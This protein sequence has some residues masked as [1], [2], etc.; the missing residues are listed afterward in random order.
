MSRKAALG[1]SILALVLS[2]HC[3]SALCPHA[4]C[5]PK[6][7]KPADPNAGNNV[8]ADFNSVMSGYARVEVVCTGWQVVCPGDAENTGSTTQQ[9]GPVYAQCNPIRL[10][11]CVCGYRLVAGCAGL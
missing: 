9:Q 2:N 6:R 10:G 4:V 3:V 5:D 11:L 1:L 8:A 7:L